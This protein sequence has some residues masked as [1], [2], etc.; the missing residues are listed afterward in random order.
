VADAVESWGITYPVADNR[1]GETWSKY[2]VRV[3][4]TFA[5]I[6]RDGSLLHRQVGRITTPETEQLIRDA[7]GS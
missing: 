6:G 3:T 5:L 2:N 1:S 4:P 7:L